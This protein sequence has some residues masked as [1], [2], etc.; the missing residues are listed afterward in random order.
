MR[1]LQP[2]LRCWQKLNL[3]WSRQNALQQ[4]KTK[5][6][7][8]LYW[9]LKKDRVISCPEATKTG[10]QFIQSFFN[11]KPDIE[12]IPAASLTSSDAAEA[13]DGGELEE[14]GIEVL[15]EDE[16]EEPAA[17]IM[18]DSGEEHLQRLFPEDIQVSIS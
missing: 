18:V 16:D 12:S 4:L 5:Q 14:I 10:Q 17:E 1:I 11:K 9:E 3:P 2:S 13:L 8:P 15:E 7:A 6:K